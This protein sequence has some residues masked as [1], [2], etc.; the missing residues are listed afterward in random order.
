MQVILAM[1]ITVFAVRSMAFI[2][3]NYIS[4]PNVVKDALELLPPA[5]LTVIIASGVLVNQQTTT[6]NFSLINHYLIA[7]LITL[8][9]A[10]K[11]KNFFAVIASGY[12]IYFLLS[13]FSG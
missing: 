13:Q 3:A 9:L 2:F 6:L 11:V 10:S 4:L 7:T 12:A 1:G 5:I 8:C